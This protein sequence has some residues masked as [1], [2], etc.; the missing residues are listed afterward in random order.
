MKWVPI[1]LFC[2]Q[3]HAAIYGKDNRQDV[4][5]RPE[6]RTTAKAIA[7][8][9]PKIFI[10]QK[11]DE[12]WEILD[13]EYLTGSS[14]FA[15]EDER[16]ANQTVIGNCTGFL[17]SP[18]HLVTAGHCIIPTGTVNNDDKNP[19]CA[20]FTWLFDYNAK[21]NGKINTASISNDFVY[22]CKRII[23]A[24]N[25]ELPGGQP[26]TNFGP[27]FAVIELDREVHPSILPLNLAKSSPVKGQEAFTIGHPSGLPAKYSGVSKFLKTDNPYYTEINLDT[28]G[29]NSGG[30][31]FNLKNE[32]V[33]ILV[34]GHAVDYYQDKKG[35][36]RANVC[37]EKGRNCNEDSQFDYLQVSNYVQRLDQLL[38]FLK[39]SN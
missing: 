22:G 5:L 36:Y 37:D 1:F 15:C 2:S 38:P 17:V 30:P 32:V 31:V 20:S 23:R 39:F 35:C 33:G 34:S 25:I 28:Q 7:A 26:G 11:T 3:L 6:L 18:K 9:V 21:V 16:F 27:D 4:Y 8:A 10:S 13:L 29:G 19:F 24:E 12:N 14:V